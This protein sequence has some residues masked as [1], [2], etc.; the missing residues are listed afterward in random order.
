MQ[1]IESENCSRE[2]YTTLVR[3]LDRCPDLTAHE[4]RLIA[5]RAIR[6]IEAELC[7]RFAPVN[8]PRP[9]A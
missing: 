5:T 7:E 3:I 1:P 6:V 8:N 2:V 9:I 4:A